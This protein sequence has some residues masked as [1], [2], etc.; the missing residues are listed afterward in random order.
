M[1]TQIT[2]RQAV[3]QRLEPNGL[4]ICMFSSVTAIGTQQITAWF[5]QKIDNERDGL[6][7]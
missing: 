2:A 3:L 4:N 6:A 1:F 5:L 7:I